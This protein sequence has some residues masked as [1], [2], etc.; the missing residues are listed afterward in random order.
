M[1]NSETLE[2]AIGMAFLFLTMSLIC[3]AIQEWIEG[4]M[5][6]RAMDLERGL[7]VL[8]DDEHGAF[9]QRLYAHP[10]I[11]SLYQGRY[12]AAKLWRSPLTP[13]L[14]AKH[15][16][17]HA[18]R[19]LPS[20]MPAERFVD[21]LLDLVARGDAPAAAGTPLSAQALREQLPRLDSPHLQRVLQ[22]ALDRSGDDLDAAR[23][24]LSHWFDGTMERAS[25]WYKR[26]TQAVLFSLGLVAAVALNIDALHVMNRLLADRALR[27]AVV[28]Q[29]SLVKDAQ[30]GLAGVEASQR[31]DILQ[32]RLQSIGMP[33]GWQADGHLPQLAAH[34]GWR[35]VDPLAWVMLALGWLV[36]AFAVMLGAPFWFDLLGRFMTLR[37]SIKPGSAGSPAGDAAAAPAP[38]R[39]TDER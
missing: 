18:R 10:L 3:T 15:M 31:L 32:G 9:T 21:A 27:E 7:R 19:Q 20:Y 35:Q 17:L 30:A 28:Q 5:K 39:P 22:W 25:G 4:V 12:D 8:L 2:V 36:S 38:A 24:H 14:G 16:R 33:I 37:S 23:Q 29:A 34:G 26:R 1:F 6:W 11:T 13:G